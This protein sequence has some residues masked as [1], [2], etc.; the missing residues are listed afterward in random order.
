MD[1]VRISAVETIPIARPLLAEH[2][3]EVALNK[4]LMV[5]EP[6]VDA[7]ERL[8]SCGALFALGAFDGE[9]LVGYSA[10]MVQQH[11]HYKDLRYAVN[12]VLFVAKSHRSGRAGIRLMQETERIAKERGA[13]LMLWHAKP[14][15]AL[16]AILPRMG[17]AVQDIIYSKAL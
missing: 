4:D 16:G 5:L 8:E 15:T 9:Q 1:I 11:L 3:E 2:W 12:D 6:N 10:T 7:Y 13:Q 14:E 17:Y